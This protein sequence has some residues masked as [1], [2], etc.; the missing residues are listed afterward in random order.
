MFEDQ[1][2]VCELKATMRFRGDPVLTSILAKMRTPSEDRSQLRL[3]D[4][5]WQVLQSTHVEQGASLDGT[6]SWYQSAFAWSYVCMAQWNRSMESARAAEKTR[7]LYAARDYITNVDNRDFLAVRNKLLKI[8]TMNRA[9]ASSASRTYRDASP[10]YN[11]SMPLPSP[12]RHYWRSAV[13]RTTSDR[14]L[15][16]GATRR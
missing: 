14:P 3:T 8:P 10:L 6:E 1:D 12:S 5:E 7:F 13:H 16:M 4:A 11:N 2:Y 9:A 15:A